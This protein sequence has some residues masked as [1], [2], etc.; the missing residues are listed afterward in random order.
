MSA[1][2]AVNVTGV[3]RNRCRY[4]ATGTDGLCA[5]HRRAF[6]VR[7]YTCRA[8]GATSLVGPSTCA[9]HKPR[10]TDA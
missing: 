6:E 1:C 2:R 9:E 5:G 7:T 10:S 3:F 8:C 4:G